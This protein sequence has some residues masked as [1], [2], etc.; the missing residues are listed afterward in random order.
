MSITTTKDV[1][2][3][4]TYTD[5]HA[6]LDHVVR[7]DSRTASLQS[8]RRYFSADPTDGRPYT[9]RNFERFD[10]GGDRADIRDA[11]TAADVLALSFLSITRGLPEVAIGTT[12]TYAGLVT[13]LLSQIPAD[14]AMH[15]APWGTYAIGS[16]TYE[17][18]R[19]FKQCGGK[20]RWVTA[21][22]L[23][24]RKR[25]HLLPVYDSQ[26][27]EVLGA[28]DSYW[29]CLWTWFTGDLQRR[30]SLEQLRDEVG[31]IEDISLLRCLDVVLWMYATSPRRQTHLAPT[32]GIRR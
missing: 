21:N 25:P 16:P 15:Q 6:L 4:D 11:A 2:R 28:P 22:K 17:L 19:L 23:L 27:K 32:E 18:W 3:A 10:G 29:A 5:Q 30:V 26:V 14:L 20:K 8:L 31:G 12:T 9:G 7:G 13:E 24:A 1:P